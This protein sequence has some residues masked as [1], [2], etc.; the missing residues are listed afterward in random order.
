M[1]CFPD[2]PAEARQAPRR[3]FVNQPRIRG[4]LDLLTQKTSVR[5]WQVAVIDI[6]LL[7]LS[8]TLL[9]W[10]T[11]SLTRATSTRARTPEPHPLRRMATAGPTEHWRLDGSDIDNLIPNSS[12]PGK[13]LVKRVSSSHGPPLQVMS[14][15]LRPSPVVRTSGGDALSRS[16]QSK[17]ASLTGRCETGVVDRL[18]LKPGRIHLVQLE[19]ILGSSRLS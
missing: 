11:I 6:L 9:S 19:R 13:A 10:W 18:I 3:K 7:L 5:A 14:A 1:R 2:V 15:N 12:P 16:S 8:V 17:G 4:S